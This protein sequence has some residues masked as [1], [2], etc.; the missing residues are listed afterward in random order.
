M[1]VIVFLYC[2]ELK[3][4]KSFRPNIQACFMPS[5]TIFALICIPVW[6]IKSLR[7]NIQACFL[8]STTI[9]ALIY[10]PVWNIPLKK[11]KSILC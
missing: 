9:F 2:R 1:G 3:L 11:R 8:H 7:P 6:N 10:I 5:T 4:F